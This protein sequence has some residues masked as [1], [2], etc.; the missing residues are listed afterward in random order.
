MLSVIVKMEQK[1]DMKNQV[2]LDLQLN[3][4]VNIYLM[5][6]LMTLVWKLLRLEKL[7]ERDCKD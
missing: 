2:I 4:V 6:H 5:L 7:K 1:L 3:Q